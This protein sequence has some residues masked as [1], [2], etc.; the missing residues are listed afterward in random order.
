MEKNRI[1]NI[2]KNN[3]IF[4][5][6]F[7]S[8]III[9]IIIYTILISI[10]SKNIEILPKKQKEIIIKD[11]IQK[12]QTQTPQVF[13]ILSQ[14]DK[15]TKKE[16]EIMIKEKIDK[17]YAPV[18]KNIDN[19]VD[20]HYSLKGD[21]TEL[22]MALNGKIEEMITDKLFKPANFNEN[23]QIALN[24]I[25]SNITKLVKENYKQI[26][27]KLKNQL[28]LSEN[29][30]NYLL[31][32]ILKYSINDTINRYK[33]Y[34]YNSFRVISSTAGA[35]LGA[36]LMAKVLAKKISQK[37]LIKAGAK[38]ATKTALS[39]G[40]ATTGAGTG[41]LVGGP[42]G[43]A[44]G[45]L[46]GGT[47]AWFASDEIVIHLDKYL[48]SKEFKQEIIKMIDTQKENTIKLLKIIYIQNLEKLHNSLN[49]NIKKLKTEPI[50]NL[51]QK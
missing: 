37:I 24:D 15:Q 7:W 51:I 44:I 31:N 36:T 17:V 45:G 40:G 22:F 18:Y 38:V 41:F 43:A 20:F 49:N 2:K 21:Y 46:I 29:E 1:N 47:I 13:E 32:N 34:N 12:L 50:K 6:S 11:L 19:F 35:T 33:E 30:I 39:A 8:I 9:G 48:N 27:S 26:K 23:F 10:A 42:I 25:N 5:Y 4:W 28:D 16:I 14:L 3:K